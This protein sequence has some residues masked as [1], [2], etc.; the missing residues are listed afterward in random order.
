MT[1]EQ[2][3]NLEYIIALE[4]MTI[5]TLGFITSIQSDEAVL[6][7]AILEDANITY[8]DLLS[9]YL[10]QQKAKDFIEIKQ[11][12]N[13]EEVSKLLETDELFILFT[14]SMLN[15]YHLKYGDIA[16]DN[17]Y[18]IRLDMARDMIANMRLQD[19]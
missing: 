4:I 11:R 14:A 7:T 3:N 2:R 13:K 8:S 6:A 17:D 10:T 12:T 19:V 18:E 16:P 5:N 1:Q 9:K 15:S